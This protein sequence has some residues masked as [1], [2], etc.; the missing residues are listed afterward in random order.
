MTLSTETILLLAMWAVGIAACLF[1]PRK[2]RREGW[3]VFLACQAINWV[4]SLVEVRLGW[5][6]FPVREFPHA[7]D[8]G[9]T[10]EFFFYPLCCVFFYIGLPR[11]TKWMQAAWLAL[12]ALGIAFFDGL[13][14]R[15]SDLLEYG[16]FSWY[17]SA[18]DFALVFALTA[19]YT[20]Q[21]FKSRAEGWKRREAS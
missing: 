20:R 10:L 18:L 4:S 13:L 1:V 5:I 12:W 7:T 11:R 19:A 8:L 9:V 16:L 3:I 14:A 6:A 2:A 21:F 15:Y 17:W